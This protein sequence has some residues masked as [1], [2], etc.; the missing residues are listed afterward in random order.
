MTAYTTTSVGE[1]IRVV[2]TSTRRRFASLSSR[3]LQ[4]CDKAESDWVR[5]VGG[6]R[7]GSKPRPTHES[8][9]SQAATSA[10]AMLRSNTGSAS[11]KV[12]LHIYQDFARFTND[13]QAGRM[14]NSRRPGA[15]ASRARVP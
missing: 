3:L 9:T 2:V 15:G 8:R 7:R 14:K 12:Y 10:S 5:S 1:F 4:L 6:D 13:T 11:R